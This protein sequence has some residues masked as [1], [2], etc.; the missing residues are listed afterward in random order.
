MQY[1]K[2]VLFQIKYEQMYHLGIF[3]YDFFRYSYFEFM[4]Q[5]KESYQVNMKNEIMTNYISLFL[6]RCLEK[7]YHVYFITEI[8][9]NHEN[10]VK[11]D[12][13]IHVECTLNQQKKR[14]QFLDM[15]CRGED[16]EKMEESVYEMNQIWNFRDYQENEMPFLYEM[17]CKKIE[18]KPK[19]VKKRRQ[20]E[21]ETDSET[22]EENEEF[23]NACQR[24]EEENECYSKSFRDKCVE[25]AYY[26]SRYWSHVLYKIKKIDDKKLRDYCRCRQATQK[27]RAFLYEDENLFR[28][29]H[30]FVVTKLRIRNEEY[31]NTDF[32]NNDEIDVTIYFSL[33]SQC[34]RYKSISEI[35]RS[36]C[37]E[38]GGFTNHCEIDKIENVDLKT[39]KHLFEDLFRSYCPLDIWH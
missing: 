31:I 34:G 12:K 30:L 39:L 17:P 8:I 13:R 20:G 25:D 14:F 36:G 28:L 4:E 32:D 10:D 16:Y 18:N 24:Y 5:Q 23:M 2:K 3:T 27:C 15:E 29:R 9:E 6:N 11:M 21:Y 1:Y 26:K 33:Q 35:C 22:E 37:Y 7:E 19:K 38:N